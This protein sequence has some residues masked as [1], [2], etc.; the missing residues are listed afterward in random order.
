[1]GSYNE[2][3]F[4][5]SVILLQSHTHA[6]TQ[7]TRVYTKKRDPEEREKPRLSPV[8]LLSLDPYFAPNSTFRGCGGR[9]NPP[10]Y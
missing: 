4:N 7:H 10:A 9:G 8:T 5:R 1:M 6:H 2:V 3:S